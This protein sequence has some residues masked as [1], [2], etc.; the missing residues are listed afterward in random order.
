MKTGLRFLIFPILCAAIGKLLAPYAVA[1]VLGCMVLN[2]LVM[3]VT[4]IALSFT[5]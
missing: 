1:F 2:V 4:I 5:P 3:V